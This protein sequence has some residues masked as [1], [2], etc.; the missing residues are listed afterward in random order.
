MAGLVDAGLACPILVDTARFL[1]VSGGVRQSLA[2]A[3]A[4]RT[5]LARVWRYVDDPQGHEL[6]VSPEKLLRDYQRLGYIAGDC[7]EAAILGAALGRAV[8][9]AARFT[10]LAFEGS[11]DGQYEH[12]YASLLTS[13]G[14]EVTLDVT[15][16]AGPVPAVSRSLSVDVV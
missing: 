16:P 15:K 1:A 2:Q 13:D 11:D 9:F 3:H 10:V 4:I 12:V 14:T 7:D 6:L 5:W 8:G